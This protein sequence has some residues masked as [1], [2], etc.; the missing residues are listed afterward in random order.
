MSGESTGLAAVFAKVFSMDKLLGRDFEKGLA[1]L[2]GVA[3][4]R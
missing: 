4:E 2:K 3:E 1:R